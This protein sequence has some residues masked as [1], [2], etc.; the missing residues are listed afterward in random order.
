MY[1]KVANVNRVP[2]ITFETSLTDEMA[3]IPDFASINLTN[4]VLQH[5]YLLQM[6]STITISDGGIG[7]LAEHILACHKNALS[8]FS[9]F[10]ECGVIA[11]SL[12]ASY[13]EN[14][15]DLLETVK[16]HTSAI[17]AAKCTEILAQSDDV[18][19]CCLSLQEACRLPPG[20]LPEPQNSTLQRLIYC[21][22]ITTGPAWSILSRS[23]IKAGQ[24]LGIEPP[25]QVLDAPSLECIIDALQ[26]HQH[27]HQPSTPQLNKLKV[28]CTRGARQRTALSHNNPP[29]KLTNPTS[30]NITPS[31][32]ETSQKAPVMCWAL[33]IGLGLC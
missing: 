12:L 26:A 22:F 27:S 32:P 7:T 10:W 4:V 28:E 15:G 16:Q 33:A 11:A 21:G 2:Y 6:E 20:I 1:L 14:G 9:L 31:P 30:A 24:A 13:L 18:E 17:S 25:Q 5:Q 23:L 29:A 19:R 8:C 3:V